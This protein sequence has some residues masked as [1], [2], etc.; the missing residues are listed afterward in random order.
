MR[1]PQGPGEGDGRLAVGARELRPHEI[2]AGVGVG[3]AAADGLVER[4]TD[5]AEGVGAR[6]DDEVGV[7]AVARVDGR[8]IL[9]D[10]LLE[11]HDHLAGD[12]AAA[13]GEHLVLDV[14][15]GHAA[16][17]VLLHRP[18]GRERVAVAVVGVGDDG[19][20]DGAGDQGAD[21]GH[22]R[23]GQEAHVGPAVGQGHR[24]AG[25]VDRLH[26]H[27]LGD[28]GVERRV[29]A[30]REQVGLGA[31]QL[32]ELLAGVTHGVSVS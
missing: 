12:V 3:A 13:L 18:D 24:V 30:A 25:Q 20:L 29:D 10:R 16:A 22:F 4:A 31:E 15:A 8:A 23:L 9:P 5:G 21:S 1:L 14:D 6:D 28:L 19:D 2:H 32:A 26:A 11:A 17:H 7:Q 27:L